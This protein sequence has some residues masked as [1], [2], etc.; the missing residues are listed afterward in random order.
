LWIAI[1]VRYFIQR[2]Q[3]WEKTANEV[4]GQFQYLK[5]AYHGMALFK[6]RQCEWR[7]KQT[8]GWSLHQRRRTSLG[9]STGQ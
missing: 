8:A 7:D 6:M 4:V 1:D 9:G 2:D 5:E 3:Y